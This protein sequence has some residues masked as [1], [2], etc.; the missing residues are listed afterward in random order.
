VT[1]VKEDLALLSFL[2]GRYKET[3][4]LLDDVRR[5]AP[6]KPRYTQMQNSALFF[7]GDVKRAREGF[8]RDILDTGSSSVGAVGVMYGWLEYTEGNLA[9]A[10]S[11]F[12]AVGV[13]AHGMDLDRVEANLFLGRI[14]RLKGEHE[15]ADSLFRDALERGGRLLQSR[16]GTADMHMRVGEAYVGLGDADT[17]LIF[18][19]MAEFLEYRPYYVGRITVAMGNAYD[20]MGMREHARALYNR[21]LDT[22]TSYAAQAEARRYLKEPYKAGRA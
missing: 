1:R 6:A 19:E 17:A 3:A 16:P 18:L 9:K 15:L 10:E 13:R 2:E 22:P 12:H 11:L 20:L 8:G 21:V 4:E 7:Q 5:S 14:K